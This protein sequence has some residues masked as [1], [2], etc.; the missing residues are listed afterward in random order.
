MAIPHAQSGEVVD[1]RPLGPALAA[2]RTTTL[3]KSKTLEILRLVVPA[4]KE[5]PSHEVPE[6]VVL[7]CLEGRVTVNLEGRSVELAAGEFIY[8]DGHRPH[9]LKAVLDSTL[10]V[11]I[12]LA[13]GQNVGPHP[14][15]SVLVAELDELAPAGPWR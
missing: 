7:Q 8:L 15:P 13:R 10:L 12:L 4:G 1:I 9:G 14:W 6:E 2:A 5:I 11:T 3:V